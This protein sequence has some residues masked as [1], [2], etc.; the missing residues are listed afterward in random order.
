MKKLDNL[1][2]LFFKVA[3]L[4]LLSNRKLFFDLLAAELMALFSNQIVNRM[5]QL[6]LEWRKNRR[7]GCGVEK[8]LPHL[9]KKQTNKQTNNSNNAPRVKPDILA[10]TPVLVYQ[11]L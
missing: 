9:A 8:L 6:N 7:V 4:F 10:P 3:I 1:L 11:W 5:P 2:Y